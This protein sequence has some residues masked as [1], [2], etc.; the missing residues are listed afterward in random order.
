MRSDEKLARKPLGTAVPHYEN[1]STCAPRT[2]NIPNPGVSTLISAPRSKQLGHQGIVIFY[3]LWP[4]TD[5]NDNVIFYG[6]WHQT[7]TITM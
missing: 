2:T 6:S 1:L 7:V 3:S 5:D 4:Y